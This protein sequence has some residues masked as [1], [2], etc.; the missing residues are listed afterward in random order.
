MAKIPILG[1]GPI[2]FTDLKGTL[3][4]IPLGLLDFNKPK[5]GI[6]SWVGFSVLSA[7]PVQSGALEAWLE[8]QIRSGYL[9]PGTIPAP[10]PAML[11]E[12]RD[13]GSSGNTIS[14]EIKNVQPNNT[15]PEATKLDVVLTETDTYKA[16]RPADLETLLGTPTSTGT[17]SGL[18]LLNMAIVPT[19]PAVT[20]DVAL[21]TGTLDVSKA[22]GAGTAFTLRAKR[23]EAAADLTKVTVKDVDSVSGQFTLV[24]TW[25]KSVTG[26]TLSALDTELGYIIK[27]SPP[28]GGI[29][30]IPKEGTFTLVGGSDTVSPL[31]ASSVIATD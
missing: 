31:K 14:I 24:V 15:T 26:T 5:R 17:H 2:Q 6:D 10:S 27:V 20:S 7:D 8:A 11:I 16:I 23:V 29:F 28:A 9:T 18:I 30:G 1:N 25:R 4:S 19:L 22:S 3:R 21:A 13:P 12:A